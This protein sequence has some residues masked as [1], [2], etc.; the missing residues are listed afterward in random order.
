MGIE[1]M[2]LVWFS[3]DKGKEKRKAWK[4]MRNAWSRSRS[5]SRYSAMF[6]KKKKRVN[7]LNLL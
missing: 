3:R 1:D 2:G 7:Y 4:G 6:G 5:R